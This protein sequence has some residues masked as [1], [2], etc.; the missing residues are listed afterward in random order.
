MDE[1]TAIGKL[2]L[3]TIRRE[4]SSLF[5]DWSNEA[6]DLDVRK[7]LAN[8]LLELRHGEE[9][10]TVQLRKVVRA[11]ALVLDL[12]KDKQTAEIEVWDLPPI[13]KVVMK[14]QELVNFASGGKVRGTI[15]PLTIG[16][17]AIIEFTEMPGAQI[18][19]RFV[20]PS[21]KNIVIR[22]DAIFRERGDR[23]FELTFPR[24]EKFEESFETLLASANR[25]STNLQNSLNAARANV[26]SL[27]SAPASPSRNVQLAAA[28]VTAERLSQQLI[29][30]QKQAGEYQA[31]LRAV[32]GVRTFMQA[33]HHRATIRFS[34]CATSGDKEIVLAE[35][36]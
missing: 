27:Q 5:F 3:A 1:S 7:Q 4:G 15:R 17:T 2:A 25:E 30:V 31:R 8:C 9:A 19:L 34:I 24:L 14:I 33:L 32:P 10:K 26:Q 18:D 12:D 23:D 13:G 28:S 21:P 22:T 6:A 20:G 16:K 36:E 35:S 11:N 29:R